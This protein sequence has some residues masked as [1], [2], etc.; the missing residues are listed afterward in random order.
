MVDRSVSSPVKILLFF[1]SDSR[2]TMWSLVRLLFDS[3]RNQQNHALKFVTSMAE[4]GR[5]WSK[6]LS[7]TVPCHFVLIYLTFLFIQQSYFKGAFSGWKYLLIYRCS[8]TSE[9]FLAVCWF[10]WVLAKIKMGEISWRSFK[11]I[12]WRLYLVDGNQNSSLSTLGACSRV[13]SWLFCGLYKHSIPL[14]IYIKSYTVSLKFTQSAP[15]NLTIIVL[16]GVV[17]SK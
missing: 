12:V 1:V 13:V 8:V 4:L 6:T 10:L 16:L 2:K 9:S 17:N 15:L 14:Y 3:P 11:I 7:S 5:T